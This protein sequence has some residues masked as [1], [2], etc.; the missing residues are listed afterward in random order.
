MAAI[1]VGNDT[2]RWLQTVHLKRN[3]RDTLIDDFLKHHSA[4]VD[5]ND[6]DN[7]DDIVHGISSGTVTATAL[8]ISY[9]S[10]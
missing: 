3:T 2:P 7:V 5:Q 6:P 4:A 8:C 1:E 10:R 9:I